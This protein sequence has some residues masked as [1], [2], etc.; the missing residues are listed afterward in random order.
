MKGTVQVCILGV[1]GGNMVEVNPIHGV[2]NNLSGH[3]RFYCMSF[4]GSLLLFGFI[5][6]N[7]N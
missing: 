4:L 3:F 5:Q 1:D 7:V 6:N 2:P